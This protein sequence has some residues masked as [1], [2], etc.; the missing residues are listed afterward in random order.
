MQRLASLLAATALCALAAAPARAV[1]YW[2]AGVD[3]VVQRLGH[4]PV[5]RDYMGLLDDPA[6]WRAGAAQV[7][8]FKISA[9][10]ILLGEPDMIRRVFNG[11]HARHIKIAVEMGS[12]VRL[13]PCGGG[14]GYA[15]PDMADKMGKKLRALGVTLDVMTLDE[16]VWYAHEIRTGMT[17]IRQPFCAYPLKVVAQRSALSVKA[18]RKY[19]PHVQV[20]IIDVVSTSLV[21]PAQLAHDE[22]EY[23]RLLQDEIGT[24][25]AFFHADVAWKTNWRAALPLMKRE[26]RALHIPFGIVID[27]SPEQHTS[28]AWVDVALQRLKAVEAD[29]ALRP[30]QIVA[31]SWQKLPTHMLPETQPGAETYLLLQSERI[32]GR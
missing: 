26:M 17:P 28:E 2:L 29:P 14:E 23:A 6:G 22:G 4:M 19:F 12:V 7:S 5:M 25:L 13:D 24:P 27:G 16:P 9:Q 10:F 11:M 8:V 3:P 21:P 20:G 31:Q 32:A 1:E 30:D 15:P 18:M